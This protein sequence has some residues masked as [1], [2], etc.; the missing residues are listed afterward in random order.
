MRRRRPPPEPPRLEV[1][2]CPPPR[3]A[4]AEI[5]ETLRKIKEKDPAIYDKE[6]KFYTDLPTDEEGE[7]GVEK[8]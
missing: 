6:A 4:E 5:F 2:P 8:R 3:P 1:P 7:G